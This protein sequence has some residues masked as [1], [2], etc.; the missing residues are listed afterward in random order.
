MIPDKNKSI[1]KETLTKLSGYLDL[2]MFSLTLL[3][4]RYYE[5]IKH[6]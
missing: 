3:N 5:K 4:N 1:S 6:F 2:Q